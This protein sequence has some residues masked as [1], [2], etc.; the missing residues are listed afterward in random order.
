MPNACRAKTKEG[1]RC[2]AT[3]KPGAKFCRWHSR[4]PVD[5]ARH[6]EESRKGGLTKAYGSLAHVE[7]LATDPRVAALNLG[8]ADGLQQLVAAALRALARLPLDV[9]TATAIGQLVTTQR[10]TIETSDIEARLRA[11]ESG[12]TPQLRV[13]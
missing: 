4:K 2:R 3:P 7:P 5:R 9:R 11:L 10:S 6:I 13:S 12:R 1:K 8:T